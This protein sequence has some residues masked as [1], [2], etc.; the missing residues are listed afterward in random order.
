MNNE[1]LRGKKTYTVGVLIAL[2]SV[3][4]AMGY[5]DQHTYM[6]LLGVLNSGGLIALRSG[7][8]KSGPIPPQE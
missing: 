5:I 6:T 3:A 4:Y 8:T 7:V 2:V 1:L